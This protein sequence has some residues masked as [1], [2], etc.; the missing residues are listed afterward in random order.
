[1]NQRGK[2]IKEKKMNE[3][4]E[5]K[6]R[7]TEKYPLT[8]DEAKKRSSNKPLLILAENTH[9]HT[10]TLDDAKENCTV[11]LLWFLVFILSLKILPYTT[12]R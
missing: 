4:K 8:L 6:V 3:G 1:V 12:I 9:T 10:H 11:I 2:K 7:H 5:K